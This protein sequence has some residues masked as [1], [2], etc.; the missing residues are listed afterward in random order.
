MELPIALLL[1]SAASINAFITAP[2]RL[3][4]LRTPALQST[5]LSDAD[6]PDEIAK[7]IAKGKSIR[8]N[9]EKQKAVEPDEQFSVDVNAWTDLD[10]LPEFKMKVPE[11]P[12]ED[13]KPETPKKK[14]D[15]EQSFGYD[16]TMDYAD[17]NEFHIPNRIGISTSSWGDPNKGF[18]ANGKLSKAMKKEGKFLPGDAQVR[19]W[20]SI[21]HNDPVLLL[22]LCELV[23]YSHAWF[24]SFGRFVSLTP[25]VLLQVAYN[26]M[27]AAGI[28]F[29]VTSETHGKASRANSLSAEHIIGKC[30]DDQGEISPIISSTYNGSWKNFFTDGLRSGGVVKALEDS[31][32]RMETTSVELFQA[33]KIFSKTKLAQGLA[34]ALEKGLCNFVGVVDMNRSDMKAVAKKLDDSDFALTSNQVSL[35]SPC[36]EILNLL[37][38]AKLT[39]FCRS[40]SSV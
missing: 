1:L 35:H 12:A 23:Y 24:T 18:V 17:E 6:V 9:A 27:L 25:V 33:R 40:L 22:H 28:T 11:K 37:G 38:S 10:K 21:Q 3:P 14:K 5:P 2:F 32:E 16:Y 7:L 15:D 29:C 31:C 26:T 20:C 13:K 4:F 39:T 8:Q 19:M 34:E 36:V 30:M